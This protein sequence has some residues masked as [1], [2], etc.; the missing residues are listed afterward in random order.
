MR[1]C[2]ISIEREDFVKCMHKAGR[3]LLDYPSSA[4]YEGAAAGIPVMSLL[5][6]LVPGIVREWQPAVNNFSRSIQR[7]S[8]I[9]EALGKIDLFLK[10]D[11]ADYRPGVG[12]SRGNFLKDL[13]NVIKVG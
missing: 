13:T 8:D 1:Y 7:F 2:N 6:D 11:P 4:F 5:P 12:V 9:P 10:G 3:I